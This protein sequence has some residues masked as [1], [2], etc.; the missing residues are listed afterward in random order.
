MQRNKTF[1]SFPHYKRNKIALKLFF[2]G[3]SAILVL[4]I[5]YFIFRNTL[6]NYGVDKVKN[7][8]KSDYGIAL[9]LKKV[10]FVGINAIRFESLVLTDKQ[11]NKIVSIDKMEASVSIPQLFTGT[12]SINELIGNNFDIKLDINNLLKNSNKISTKTVA[13]VKQTSTE[14]IYFLAGK[15]FSSL[16]KIPKNIQITQFTARVVDSSSVLKFDLDSLSIQNQKALAV[17]KIG[18][19]TNMVSWKV[20]GLLNLYDLKAHLSIT[21]DSAVNY[22]P[23]DF[24][25]KFDLKAGFKSLYV[26]IDFINYNFKSWTVSATIDSYGAHLFQPKIADKSVDFNRAGI[27]TQFV[28]SKNRIEF[29]SNSTIYFNKVPVKFTAFIDQEKETQLGCTINTNQIEATDFFSSLPE[30]VF[31]SIYGLKASGKMEMSGHFFANWTKKDSLDFDFKL[32]STDFQIL[33]YGKQSLTKLN[34]GFIYEPFESNRNIILGSENPNF[35]P[36]SEIPPVLIK[37]VLTSEDNLFWSHK[38]FYPEAFTRAMLVNMKKGKFLKGGSSIS[39]QLVKNVFLTRAK[40]VSRKVEEALITWI[41]EQNRLT[42]KQRMLEIYLNIIEWGP[43]IYGIGE[44][45]HFYFNK[46]PQQLTPEEAIFLTMIIPSPKRF[47]WNFDVSG[48][49]KASRSYYFRNLGE[50]LLK[51]EYTLTTST[52]SLYSRVKLKGPASLYLQKDSTNYSSDQNEEADEFGI[53]N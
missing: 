32:N 24:L 11:L 15:I 5:T 2:V 44:A 53:F 31:Q 51:N 33:N 4:T 13:T 21:L 52:D 43:E 49:V 45:S 36:F 35:I 41:I 7:K 20:K 34:T 1:S 38:G 8:L 40:Y 39:Q 27:K 29:D 46:F 6:L 12:I 3:F 37:C 42:S 28:I 25:S 16:K 50:I 26:K 9:G 18:N 22:L 48:L 30:G 10:S 23:L 14:K 19:D 47:S 17:G